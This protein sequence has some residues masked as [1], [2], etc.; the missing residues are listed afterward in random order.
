MTRSGRRPRWPR[1]TGGNRPLLPPPMTDLPAVLDAL[2][3]RP[4]DRPRWLALSSWLRD[5]GRDDEAD[6]VRALWPALRDSLAAAPLEA[7]LGDVA[8]N[9]GLLSAVAREVERR[10]L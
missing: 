5:N 8:R 1:S 3:G 7:T 10:A 9:A 4:D 6:V 2:R